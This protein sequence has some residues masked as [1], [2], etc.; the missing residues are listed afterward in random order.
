MAKSW[1]EEFNKTL[2]PIT[3]Y[4]RKYFATETQKH[5]L[6]ANENGDGICMRCGNDVSVVGRHLSK[7]ECPSCKHTMIL[8]H[9]WRTSQRPK[10]SRWFA[11][12]KAINNHIMCIR[13]IQV[14]DNYV[15]ERG[16]IYIDEYRSDMEYWCN[17]VWQKDWTK[18]KHPFFVT[19]NVFNGYGTDAVYSATPYMKTLFTE[20]RKLD[21]FNRYN[22]IE[23]VY[24]KTRMISQLHY[25]MRSAKV[26]E[27]LS[28]S[29]F[30]SL[31]ADHLSYYMYQGHD[32]SYPVN[33]KATELYKVLKLSKHSFNLWKKNA[34]VNTLKLYQRWANKVTPERVNKYVAA[35]RYYWNVDNILRNLSQITKL[36]NKP[37]E[38]IER[39]VERKGITLSDY[40]DYLNI[41]QKLGYDMTD[42][43]YIMPRDFGK[44]KKRVCDE[45]NALADENWV[46]SM[47]AKSAV[48]KLISDG[49]KKMP[50]L[51]EYLN[52]SKGL[53][54]YIP[55]SARDMLE[56]GRSLH[57]CLKN[58]V[59]R[60]ANK[61]T[62][63][64]FIRQLDNPTAPFVSM[65]YCNGSIVQCRYDNN[66]DVRSRDDDTSRNII[67]FAEAFASTLRN[68]NVLVA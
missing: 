12:A 14:V 29:G 15:D 36:I 1:S 61:K 19:P 63:V 11:M 4:Q 49:L 37:M 55:E 58:Y 8:H 46:R 38:V 66:E 51:G 44:D 56:E 35:Q 68:N 42:K 48:M 62:M 17:S 45:Q 2:K 41:I 18:G 30:E 7:V 47:D 57:N 9:T 25:L 54:V 52:G 31:A 3:E 65:E 43:Q 53:L 21:C 22:P 10:D 26:N 60:V 39:Y 40:L 67:N 24:D 6:I 50:N 64:F 13:Y 34:D 5:I 59:D 32:H 16:R 28:K 23:K 20:C 27:M 33:N